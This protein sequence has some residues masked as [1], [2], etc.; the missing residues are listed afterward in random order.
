M[1]RVKT[2]TLNPVFPNVGIEK[3]YQK[4][5]DVLINEM[6]KSLLYW[7]S[8]EYKR[9]QPELRSLVAEDASPASELRNAVRRLSRRWLR[10][11][12]EAAPK[13]A[14]YFAM[15]A[16]KRSDAALQSILR[17]GG[18]SVKFK[19]GRAAND[20][21]Q[22]I[23]H[24]NVSLIKSIAQQHLTQVEGM[25]MR[26]VQAGRDLE[27]LN[28]ELIHQF[29]VTKR[30]AA[31]IARDQNNKA[32]A[33]IQRVRQMELGVTECVWMH[34]GAGKEPRPTHVKAGR[35]KQRYNP[36]EGWLD[37]AI[38]KRIWPGT[39]I[40]CLP[41]DS[42]IEFTAGCSKIW[43]RLY[44][45]E[46]TNIISESGKTLCA[47]PNHPILTNRGW[48]PIKAVRPGDYII[49]ILDEIPDSIKIHIQRDPT[50]ISQIFNTASFFIRP[51]KSN[52]FAEFHGDI[53]DGE[54]DTIDFNSFLPNEVNSVFC[55][56]F[57]EFFFANAGHM[58]VG[59]G[60]EPDRSFYTTFYRL[61]RTPES[62]IGGFCTLLS[63]LKSHSG[64]ANNVSNGLIS[65]LN[66]LLDKSL[67][68]NASTNLVF[69]RQSKLANTGFVF[70]DDQIIGEIF[71]IVSRASVLWNADSP[72]SDISRNNITA[73]INDTGNF[74]D[75]KFFNSK[76]LDRVVDDYRT[77]FSRH[78]FNLETSKGYYTTNAYLVHNCRC[79]G[80]IVLP[81]FS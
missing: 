43:R 55:K 39:E 60:F 68:Y 73:H 74:F 15:T 49:E 9:N 30:R 46:L 35:D 12:N 40:N 6:H 66:I 41:G 3:S 63:L 70:G 36:V 75:C 8:V 64:G 18:I 11:F 20:V 34:S 44:N 27:S 25:V 4:K 78:V 21:L 71:D 62:V 81:G 56:K 38:N 48:L 19:M 37:P 53:S 29:G 23:V 51:T 28:K 67:S 24:E 31:L 2:K 32:T 42:V 69:F 22:S 80:R 57:A 77:D 7:I 65:K 50:T 33:A 13:L 17:R 26:S 45:G 16:S 52:T 54:V 72:S 59:A 1:S 79:T 61:F 47:T 5:L 58:L 14:S 76:K 10:R